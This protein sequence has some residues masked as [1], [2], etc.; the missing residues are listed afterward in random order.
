MPHAPLPSCVVSRPCP[1]APWGRLAQQLRRRRLPLPLQPEREDLVSEV[2]LRVFA[3]PPPDGNWS[4]WANRIFS[5]LALDRLRAMTRAAQ[6]H[7]QLAW[8]PSAPAASPEDN[9]LAH[10]QLCAVQSAL[11]SLPT[12]LHQAVE[13]RFS[14]GQA[15][16]QD[17]VNQTTAR[18]HVH[19]GIVRLRSLL[20]SLRAVF[21]PAYAPIVTGSIGAVMLAQVSV[22]GP[23]TALLIGSSSEGE[24][25]VLTAMMHATSRSRVAVVAKRD[26]QRAK[27]RT[28]PTASE[29]EPPARVFDFDDDVVDGDL[30]APDVALVQVLL[31]AQH[32]SLLEIPATMI[33]PLLKSLEDI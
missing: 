3:S 22:S 6:A 21:V 31:T 1:D 10:E 27:S 4:P 19:R 25:R 8:A 33:E 11:Q 5:N 9:A 26:E 14:T 12:A 28:P 30:N 2:L 18:V 23:T 32:N 20:S 15:R 29:T 13:A 24:G 16:E 17:D 7:A